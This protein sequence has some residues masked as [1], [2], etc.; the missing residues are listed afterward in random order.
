LTWWGK[1]PL[2]IRDHDY[3]ETVRARK[4]GEIRPRLCEWLKPRSR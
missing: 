3:P 1:L 4:Y 2:E